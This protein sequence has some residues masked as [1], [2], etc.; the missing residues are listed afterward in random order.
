MCLCMYTQCGSFSAEL[1]SGQIQEAIGEAVNNIIKHF[2]KPE[3][4]VSSQQPFQ[5][6]PLYPDIANLLFLHLSSGVTWF[7]FKISLANMT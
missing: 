6:P 5:N 3:K 7:K 1:T 2:H 4:E